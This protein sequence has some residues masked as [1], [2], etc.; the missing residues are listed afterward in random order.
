MRRCRHGCGRD[1]RDF[2]SNRDT[3]VLF[4]ARSQLSIAHSFIRVAGVV[5]DAFKCPATDGGLGKALKA[6]VQSSQPLVQT[7]ISRCLR[8]YAEQRDK[9]LLRQVVGEEQVCI[10]HRRPNGDGNRVRI[11]LV[12]QGR[13]RLKFFDN[14]SAFFDRDCRYNRSGGPLDAVRDLLIILLVQRV[15]RLARRQH[16]IQLARAFEVPA[17]HRSM[18]Q[19]L[20][21]FIDVRA[22]ARLLKKLQQFFERARIVLNGRDQGVQVRAKFGRIGCQQ[23]FGVGAIDLECFVVVAKP[24]RAFSQQE[25]PLGVVVNRQELFRQR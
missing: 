15:L 22:F 16:L 9:R 2:A 6:R 12:D 24:G 18:G 25:Q 3:G 17:L 4:V 10:R 20:G 13:R 23:A 11:H 21:D 19:Q 14:Q 7:D 8:Q 5:I 1:R